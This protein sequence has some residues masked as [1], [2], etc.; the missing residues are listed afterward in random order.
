MSELTTD[1]VVKKVTYTPETRKD[2]GT[3][4]KPSFFSIN[5]NIFP[6]DIVAKTLSELIHVRRVKEFLLTLSP[7][8]P[9]LLTSVSEVS[10]FTF[11]VKQ[12]LFKTEEHDEDGNLKQE[13]YFAIHSNT[14]ASDD[15]IE[16]ICDAI[17]SKRVSQFIATL[18]PIG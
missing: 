12:S 1:C 2:D 14:E 15:A 4:K 8:Q 16:A 13:C 3:L 5:L 17:F 7:K 11:I 9:E 18:K 6:T 10:E